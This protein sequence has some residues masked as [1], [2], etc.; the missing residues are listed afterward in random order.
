MFAR[1]TALC[2]ALLISGQVLAQEGKAVEKKDAPAPTFKVGD[3]APA[4]SVE[5]WL[6][7][8]PIEKFE[9]GKIYVVECWATWCGPCMASIPHLTALQAE[10]KDVTI[11]GVNIWEGKHGDG[12]LLAKVEKF[13]KDKGGEMAYTVAFDGDA[14]AV[15]EAYMTASGSDGIPT[16]FVVDKD[17][18]LAWF[19][20][21]MDL[22][23][24]LEEMVAG[25]FD[26]KVGSL[27]L[28][29]YKK[30]ED[31]VYNSLADA[32]K[33]A[34][35]AFTKLETE[36]PKQAAARPELK[37]Q[38]LLAAGEYEKAYKLMAVRVEKLIA[39][40]NGAGLNEI[41]W[42]IV[43]PESKIAKRDL[44]LAMKAAAKAA[45][46][47]DNKDAA[48]LDTL[49]LVHFLKGDVKKAVEVQTKAVELAP[50]GLKAE[51]QKRLDEYKA[52]PKK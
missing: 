19:G 7:G 2:A 8:K 23:F 43:D 30:L 24:I 17:G 36:F 33:D 10:Y 32:P 40:K 15:T 6:K 21:P 1:L 20:H 27:K 48:V 22:D 47:T 41:G 45:E 13:V 18:K 29:K 12:D 44:D 14:K 49:A 5:K 4:L 34:L 11:I 39:A 52:A 31:A 37:E 28:E 51:L 35:A 3:K 46:F 38:V 50:D 25:K 26:P 9:K 42:T 16:A